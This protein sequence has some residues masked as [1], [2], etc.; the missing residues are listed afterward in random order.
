MNTRF[1]HYYKGVAFN[2]INEGLDSRDESIGHCNFVCLL[3]SREAHIGLRIV[4]G[5]YLFEFKSK[6][7]FWLFFCPFRD[8]CGTAIVLFF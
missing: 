6:N 1:T 8:T 5:Y 2:F 4:L 7:G 3:K